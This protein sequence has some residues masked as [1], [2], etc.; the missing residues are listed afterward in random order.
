ML[1]INELKEIYCID[2]RKDEK[3]FW[4]YRQALRYYHGDQIDPVNLRTILERRQSPVI[5]NIFKLIIN[6]I[7]GYKA[8]SIAEIKV[9][10][11]QQEDA[12][13]AMLI[14]DILKVFSE[15]VGYNK[16]IIKRD[17]SLIFGMGVCEL[18]IEQDDEGDFFLSLKSLEPTSFLIDAYSEDLNALDARRF[19]KKSNVDLEQ[20]TQKF[21]TEPF[22]KSGS[23]IDKRC[24]LIESWIKEGNHYARYIW[25]DEGILSYEPKPFKDGSHPFI[26]SKYNID[27][28]GT[29]YGLFRDIK[30]LQDYINYS[31]NKMMNMIG[32]LKAFF[33]EDAV[34]E[35][36]EF[37]HQA[38]LDNAV[39]KVKSGALR[40]NKLK[41]VEHH[42]DI[43][44]I[45]RK[46]NEKRQLAKLIS[47]L[48][49]EAL[50]I[51]NARMSNEAITQRREAGLMG[52]QEYLNACDSMDR[53]IFKKAIDYISLYFTKQQAFKI[54]DARVGERY[55]SIN[56][57]EDN[58]IRVGKFDLSYKSQIKMQSNDEKLA[59]WAEIIKS[60]S[61]DPALM[62]EMMLLML[63]DMQ[64][65][66]AADLLELIER[67]RQ[68]VAQQGESVEMQIHQENLRLEL[69]KKKAEIL[70][71]QAKT[72]KYSSQGDLARG[73]AINQTVQ[74]EALLNGEDVKGGNDSMQKGGI[75]LR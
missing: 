44:T 43:A 35:T 74:N 25:Q 5:E 49:D 27:A 14:N 34:L 22:V 21:K 8:Q 54:T 12:A 33:E 32:T 73:V 60:F 6:K 47:G 38:S 45:S 69:E 18:W 57:N 3:S 37:I 29:W 17:K 13:T 70:E 39:V 62:S 65:A 48:N 7:V 67:K 19:H 11:R 31:E 10:G 30:P 2:L 50:G 68:E 26:V 4:E 51:S 72:K 59:S 15:D 1:S 64:S 52:L 53:L 56:E 28:E 61:H 46:A 41:F 66:Q 24:I 71:L 36:E 55:F 9:S 23:S 40:D 16:E 63:K 20:I 58:R 75:D 42:N